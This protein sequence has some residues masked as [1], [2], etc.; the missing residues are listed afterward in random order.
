MK[1]NT[2]IFLIETLGIWHDSVPNR[3]IFVIKECFHVDNTGSYPPN[4]CVA[5]PNT[6]FV[7]SF[8]P[9]GGYRWYTAGRGPLHGNWACNSLNLGY[10]SCRLLTH[11]VYHIFNRPYIE[12]KLNRVNYCVS[13]RRLMY[14]QSRRVN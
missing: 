14:S 5:W 6:I 7:P 4:F 8:L 11:S 10:S 3:H 1:N 2:I 12:F 9:L 13:L